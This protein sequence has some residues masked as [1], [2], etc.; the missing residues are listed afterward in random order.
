MLTSLRL[1]IVRGWILGALAVALVVNP[2]RFAQFM[3]WL[4]PGY[5]LPVS[6][7]LFQVLLSALLLAAMFIWFHRQRV[8]FELVRPADPKVMF[9]D[10]LRYVATASRWASTDSRND[11]WVR[12]LEREVLDALSIGRVTAFGRRYSPNAER[13]FALSPIPTEFWRTASV[14]T[15]EIMN[16]RSTQQT[17]HSTK[18]NGPAYTEVFFDGGQMRQVWAR[19]SWIAALAHRSP[20]ER[21]GNVRDWRERDKKL[22]TLERQIR[23]GLWERLHGS[24]ARAADG[25][26]RKH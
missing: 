22:D 18:P 6:P 4:K 8:A 23:D 2:V 17:V 9:T 1:L 20:A 12:R 10:M 3:G 25:A 19:R 24:D 13:E 11:D 15:F 26:A 5:T 16:E 7:L 14:F 21:R